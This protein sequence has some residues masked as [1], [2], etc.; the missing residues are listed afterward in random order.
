M[1]LVTRSIV[2]A[3][4]VAIGTGSTA[5]ASVVIFSD[6]FTRSDSS[7][8]G[9]PAALTH[10]KDGQKGGSRIRGRRLLLTRNASASQRFSAEEYESVTLSFVYRPLPP[11]DRADELTL[12]LFWRR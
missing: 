7:R 10:Q 4:F 2:I 12:S 9:A 8:I 6:S 11:S 1:R 3:I 5:F